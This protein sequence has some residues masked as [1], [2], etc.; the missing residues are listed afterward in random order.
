M[1]YNGVV[2]MVAI[3]GM[4]WCLSVRTITF[5]I[6]ATMQATVMTTALST[7]LAPFSLPALT[8]PA[9]LTCTIWTLINPVL[10]SSDSFF[11]TLDH[12]TL[13]E[14]HI[15]RLRVASQI[16]KVLLSD[17][18][19]IAGSV[20]EMDQ[21][22]KVVL[23]CILCA[24][25]AEG[26]ARKIQTWIDSGVV[27]VNS[28]DF[29]GRTA[30]HLAA[31]EGNEI[32]ARLLVQ[33]RAN[34]NPMDRFGNTPL[35]DAVRENQTELIKFLRSEGGKIH[36]PSVE[37]GTRLCDAAS[38]G[39]QDDIYN[40]CLAGIHPDTSDYDGRTAL[41]IAVGNSNISLVRRLLI[42]GVNPHRSPD[43]MGNTP[44]G[45]AEKIGDPSILKILN[46]SREEILGS[47]DSTGTGLSSLLLGA[48]SSRKG[49]VD[50]GEEHILL[51]EEEVFEEAL[52][53]RWSENAFI[54]TEDFF[55]W[56]F[57]LL[58]EVFSECFVFILN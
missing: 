4:F 20:K 54:A 9:A 22:E 35:E 5:A 36:R 21:F 1:G 33:M 25:A 15:R 3:G 34:I 11:I 13:P 48:R 47:V 29:D 38:R 58:R 2:V 10:H 14:D 8:F 23:P 56:L 41:H 42:A 18:R 43:V 19:S 39:N 32:V 50:L 24:L 57:L 31:A 27:D 37:M 6:L 26:K 40:L 45:D 7:F 55:G 28:A 30:L 46:L 49:S 12:M 16:S 17:P 44:Y 51:E 53:S 52:P